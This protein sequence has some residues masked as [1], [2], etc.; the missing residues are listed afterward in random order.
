[1][2]CRSAEA[3]FHRSERRGGGSSVT[4]WVLQHQA[5]KRRVTAKVNKIKAGEFT[6]VRALQAVSPVAEKGV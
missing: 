3:R 4:E 6:S 1:M 5:A 2:S